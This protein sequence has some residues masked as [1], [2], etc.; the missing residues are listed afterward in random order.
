MDMS[1]SECN[2]SIGAA[3]VQNCNNCTII[4]KNYNGLSRDEAELLELYRQLP[5]WQRVDVATYIL[6]L[7]KALDAP[8]P[9]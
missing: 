6:S 3:I 7:K 2:A 1:I 5:I 8:K 9:E 4:V